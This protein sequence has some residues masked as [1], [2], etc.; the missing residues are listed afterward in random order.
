[1][2]YGMDEMS[3]KPV[4]G[5]VEALFSGEQKLMNNVKKSISRG[6]SLA[7]TTNRKMPF[8]LVMCTAHDSLNSTN[9]VS[10]VQCT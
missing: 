10:H 7:P 4:N 2:V 3:V 8:I 1:M 5:L 6:Q 9:Q